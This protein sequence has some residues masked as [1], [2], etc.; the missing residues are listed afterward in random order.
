MVKSVWGMLHSVSPW[1]SL[2]YGRGHRGTICSL[3][4]RGL[5]SPWLLILAS[6]QNPYLPMRQIVLVSVLQQG[7][8]ASE[9]FL[10]RP[11][12]SGGGSQ[13][14]VQIRGLWSPCSSH[15]SSW[16]L[17]YSSFEQ[18]CPFQTV[19]WVCAQVTVPSSPQRACRGGS[20]LGFA[21]AGH[22]P[23]SLRPAS[24]HPSSRISFIIIVNCL[25]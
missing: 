18:L 24:S 2:W 7:D 8:G 14:Q 11:R 3:G 5:T 1:H 19:G 21:H 12:P 10:H 9:A 16:H 20:R 25:L 4:H 13:I 23:H 17:Q 6:P 22:V 15:R